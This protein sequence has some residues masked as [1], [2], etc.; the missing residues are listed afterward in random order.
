MLETILAALT[1]AQTIGNTV[2]DI[3]MI[4][5]DTEDDQVTIVALR[6]GTKA[7]FQEQVQTAKDW[8]ATHSGGEGQ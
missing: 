8:L 3:V 5:R 6:E 2:K 1:S 4:F 7:E